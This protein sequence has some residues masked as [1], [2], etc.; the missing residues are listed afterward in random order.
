MQRKTFTQTLLA[1]AASALIVPAGRASA[2][3]QADAG[4]R[5]GA[6]QPAPRSCREVRR[7]AQGQERRA[8]R[9]ASRTVGAARRRCRD[10]D[11]AAHRRTRHVGQLARCGRQRDTRIRRLRH[12]LPVF[13]G[14]PGLQGAGRPA[15]QGAFRQVCGEGADRAR[16]LG[17]RHP[18]HDQQQ[19]PDH[20][21]RGHEGPEDAHPAR[22]R[23][24]GHHAIARRRGAADQVRRAV[25]RACSK[26]WSTGRR[27]R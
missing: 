26:A 1:L 19:A 14:R 5:R 24:G 4:P 7:S 23:A 20:Q 9:G 3:H 12:A 13:H 25:R 17:Q 2:D 15:G 16:L 10:A 21:G 6:R 27:T 22:H 8:H 18:P 11:R